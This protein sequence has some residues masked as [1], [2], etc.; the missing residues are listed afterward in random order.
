MQVPPFLVQIGDG[1]RSSRSDFDFKLRTR[2]RR[3]VGSS[4]P[5][6]AP[7]TWLL[8]DAWGAHAQAPSCVE[9]GATHRCQL[10]VRHGPPLAYLFIKKHAYPGAYGM[11]TPTSSKES[12][13]FIS[14]GFPLFG[15]MSFFRTNTFR[16]YILMFSR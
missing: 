6:M 2:S 14:T 11:M 1:L 9:V 4:T 7:A 5:A 16:R 15:V 12:S 8:S 10:A 3:G 13:P